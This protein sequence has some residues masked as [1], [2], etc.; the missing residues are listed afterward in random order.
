MFR[1][2]KAFKPIQDQLYVKPT[3]QTSALTL[4]GD[5]FIIIDS[6]VRKTADTQF[7][8]TTETKAELLATLD[9]HR[10]PRELLEI[11]NLD[12]L[13]NLDCCLLR[14][15]DRWQVNISKR[16]DVGKCALQ[17]QSC[18]KSAQSRMI[19]AVTVAGRDLPQPERGWCW[20]GDFLRLDYETRLV[21][22]V[23][24]PL[25]ECNVYS[26]IPGSAPVPW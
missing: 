16:L 21:D 3:Q 19:F 10:I 12:Q 15:L 22:A 24:G 14:R 1:P 18:S 26:A 20:V 17:E 13:V 9:Q 23:L 5:D 11:L 6:C 2:S 4:H 8:P 7:R 25:R